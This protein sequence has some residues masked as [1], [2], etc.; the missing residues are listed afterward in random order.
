MNVFV[1]STGRSGTT[2]F[3]KA[4]VHLTNFSSA[5]ESNLGKLK[6]RF[7]YPKNHIEIDN[8]LSWMLGRLDDTF[9]KKAFYVHLISDKTRNTQS[10]FKRWDGTNSLIRAY[11]QGILCRENNELEHCGDFYET[12]HANIRSFL[13]DKPLKMTLHLDSIQANFP[14]FLKAIEAEGDLVA[15][16]AEWA[17]RHNS[18]EEQQRKASF[19]NNP[20]YWLKSKA[21]KI[22]KL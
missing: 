3:A 20:K 8:R 16:C 6:N 17:V 14:V 18:T 9:G 13:K 7:I 2:T 10:F 11:T 15:A 22:F 19:S 21:R 5:H 4:C 1:L 12:V